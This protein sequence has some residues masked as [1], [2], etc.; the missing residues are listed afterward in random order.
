MLEAACRWDL[1]HRGAAITRRGRPN[2]GGIW[3]QESS[4]NEL[5]M[6]VPVVP[7][8]RSAS[9]KPVRA[10][11]ARLFD[12][13]NITWKGATRR[14]SPLNH[15]IAQKHCKRI[16]RSK[17]GKKLRENVINHGLLQRCS[18]DCRV[19]DSHFSC[20]CSSV[21][22]CHELLLLAKTQ[23]SVEPSRGHSKKA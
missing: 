3:F 14:S 11:R 9:G 23:L 17:P 12:V 19:L 20:A 13:L 22:G 18:F 2:A 15:H 1:V 8:A 5:C 7:V 10:P 4:E 21:Q 6:R 16:R